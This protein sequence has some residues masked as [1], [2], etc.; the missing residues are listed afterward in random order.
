[1]STSYT[2]YSS[3]RNNTLETS[4]ITS[5]SSIS[6]TTDSSGTHSVTTF[7]PKPDLE[8]CPNPDEVR[9][10]FTTCIPKNVGRV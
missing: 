9:F 6:I 7:T 5:T 8:S 2:S 10:N 3:T 1:M 4:L